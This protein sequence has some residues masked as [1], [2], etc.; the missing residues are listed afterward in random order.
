MA[1]VQS[2][3]RAFAILRALS[4]GG[5]G[6]TELSDKVGLPKSTVA[7]ILAALETEGVVAQEESG[8][9]Y[10]LGA[11]LTDL[12]SG[13]SP[14]RNLAA[15]ARPHLIDLANRLGETAGISVIDDRSVYYLDHVH[16]DSDVQVRDW[17]G[18]TAPLHLVPSGL[19]LLAASPDAEVDRFL[20]LPLEATTS[21]SVVDPTEVRER[22]EQVRSAGY[23]WFHEEFAEGINSVAAAVF[24]GSANA[25]AAL[26]V[27]GPAYRFPNPDRLHDIGLTM[28]EAATNL[29][30]QLVD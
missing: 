2:I 30:A 17:T 28:I 4:V 7:R 24:D 15:T 18:E 29:A 22:I 9:E 1:G 26:H 3:E 5:H 14:G 21:L 25:V 20:S 27:H 8:G 11:G 10:C 23:V 6:V 12:A 19:V 13:M 16:L